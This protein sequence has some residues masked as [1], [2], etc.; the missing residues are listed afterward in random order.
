MIRK[1]RPTDFFKNVLTLTTG[2]T[3]AQA[4]AVLIAPVLTRLYRP[5]DFGL[6]T[7]FI[8]VTALLGT[9]VTGKY[10]LAVVLPAR[11]KDARRLVWLSLL[12]TAFCSVLLLAVVLLLHDWLLTHL[13]RDKGMDVWLYLIPLSVFVTGSFEALR[14]YSLRARAY[15]SIAVSSVV[16]S[17]TATVFQVAAGLGGMQAAGLL[18]GNLLSL[19]SGNLGVGKVFLKGREA[20]AARP[21]MKELKYAAFR[22]RNFPKFTLP[23]SLL[24]TA[25]LQLPVYVFTVFFSHT[26]VGLYALSQRVLSTPMNIV[27]AAIGQVYFQKAAE[28]RGNA[29]QIRTLTWGLYKRLLWLGIFPIAILMFRGDALFAWVFGRE[30]LIAGQYAQSLSLW[31]LFVFIS[32]PLSNLFFVQEKQKQGLIL[33]VIIFTS[34][35][36]VLLLCILQ[37]YSAAFTVLLFGITGAVLFFLF[38]IY[39]L[40]SVGIS[41]ITIISYTC[42]AAAAGI[43][44]V[45]LIDKLLS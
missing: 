33:Q 11:D 34:R 22:Y 31:F 4:I 13:F 40:S 23:S 5:A 19:F 32:S 6:L 2:T 7:V 45:Y 29:E 14:Y 28:Y 27:G 44:P 42:L 10:E 38:I 43:I 12:L 37:Q 35:A 8:S 3:I 9:V 25:S 1:A 18:L 41:R 30:W 17:G 24:N 15:K 16:R 36:A 20:G 26:V 39:L 21:G